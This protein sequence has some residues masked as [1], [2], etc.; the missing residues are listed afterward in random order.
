[1]AAL[2]PH[3]TPA[4]LCHNLGMTSS[5]NDVLNGIDVLARGGFAALRGQR[6]GLVTNHTGLRRDGQATIDALHGAPGITLAALFGPEHGIRGEHDIPQIK[7][8]TDDATGLPVYSLYGARH[9]PVPEQLQ[10]LDT[11]VFDI[12]DIGCRFYTYISTLGHVLEA[13]NTHGLRVVVLD[14]PNPITG[15]SVEGPIADGDR[16][17]FTAYH[18]LPVRHGMT[19]GELARLF[20]G[21]KRHTCELEIIPCEGWHRED[22][23]DATGLL[24]TDPSPNMR[25]LTEATLY[26]GVGLLEMTNVSVGR[27][28]NTPFEVV[29]APFIEPRRFAAVLNA[30]GL[31][32]I[33]FIPARFTPTTSVHAQM[34]CGGINLLVTDRQSFNA[35]RVG[36]TLALTL[37]QL[38]PTQWQSEKFITLL[39]N[40]QAFDGVL[41]G[42][43]YDELA[44]D[45]EETLSV[46]LTMRR[47]Y[48]AY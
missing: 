10:S 11:L 6:V 38:Y 26:P 16:L 44:H 7:D 19:A 15:V 39:A 41:E 12:Q 18:P 23:Y 35:V 2:L 45:W 47:E 42:K 43:S 48:L 20:H 27:G 5:S 9:A 29:G 37:S 33:R 14:R 3:P 24:W 8:S 40:K 34:L 13:A 17:S 32:G 22:W 4:E 46:F 36:L 28:T 21:E 25:S 1:M 31:P 30:E